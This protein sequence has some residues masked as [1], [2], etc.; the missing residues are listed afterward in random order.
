MLV[1][2]DRPLRIFYICRNRSLP[3]AYLLMDQLYDHNI[4]FVNRSFMI[5][6][7]RFYLQ[8]ES[9]STTKKYVLQSLYVCDVND[10][11]LSTCFVILAPVVLFFRYIYNMEISSTP[12]KSPLLENFF[13]YYQFTTER[14]SIQ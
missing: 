10:V 5:G 7:F 14:L 12:Q 1:K 2:N 13:S 6:L 3:S 9:A 4:S 8:Q 11:D